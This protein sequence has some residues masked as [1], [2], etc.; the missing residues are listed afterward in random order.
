MMLAIVKPANIIVHEVR[1]S[2]LVAHGCDS[3]VEGKYE[4]RCASRKLEELLDVN[5]SWVT[6]G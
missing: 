3:A 6:F 5:A 2:F 1:N 4:K